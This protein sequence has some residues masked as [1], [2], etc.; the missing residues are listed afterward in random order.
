VAPGGSSARKPDSIR[1]ST[2][3]SA[4]YS[5]QRL[6]ELGAQ[7]PRPQ[8]HLGPARR[9]LLR[10]V[11]HPAAGAAG[12]ARAAGTRAAGAGGVGGRLG[13][14]DAADAERRRGRERAGHGDR[15]DEERGA[16]G[17]PDGHD[18]EG[19]RE[20]DE[21][22]DHQHDAG[23]PET[24]S[25]ESAGAIV[26]GYWSGLAVDGY[27]WFYRPG[28]SAGMIPTND[29]E[30]CVF[31]GLPAA[32]LGGATGGGRRQAYHRLLAAATDGAGGRLSQAR[33]PRR[34]RTWVGRPGYVRRAH[35]PG[36]VLVGDAGSFLDPLSTHGITDAPRDAQLPAS[37]LP[38]GD[39]DGDLDAAL[40]RFADDRDRIV[41]P[42][43][44]VVDRIA[45]YRWDT[46]EVRRHLLD[47]SSALGRELDQVRELSA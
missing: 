35:G 34:L 36:W 43:F 20:E 41:G 21:R 28:H 39:A 14:H 37:A 29:G 6:L 45:G 47:L 4:P 44:D 25:G 16:R 38:A 15:G 11:R 33:R 8:P 17:G 7:P 32:E 26:Y 9:R 23:A 18:A 1:E 46:A 40:A 5:R 30:V 24:R 10:Q 12:A 27:E 22:A 13:Q 3:P 19:R 2:S 42:I 31:A